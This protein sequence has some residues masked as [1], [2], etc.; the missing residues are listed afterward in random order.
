MQPYVDKWKT[1]H[2]AL[3]DLAKIA[4]SSTMQGLKVELV[5]APAP[6]TSLPE[7]K[8]GLVA[9]VEPVMN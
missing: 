6:K 1:Y 5:A 9:A 7:T 4:T 3:D 8:V 2:D